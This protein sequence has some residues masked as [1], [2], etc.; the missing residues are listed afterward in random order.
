MSGLDEGTAIFKT[1]SDP[2]QGES[3]FVTEQ[4]VPGDHYLWLAG[5]AGQLL[6][7]KI[8]AEEEPLPVRKK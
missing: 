4:D 8:K 2:P 6:R 1:R 7:G 5:M 3:Q